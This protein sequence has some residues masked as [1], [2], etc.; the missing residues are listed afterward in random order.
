VNESS[1]PE[2]HP[3]MLVQVQLNNSD[4]PIEA[5]VRE[6]G[7]VATQSHIP[8]W[9]RSTCPRFVDSIPV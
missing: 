8:S 6:I 1:L 9:S 7:P 2:L 3:G 4:T 5:K